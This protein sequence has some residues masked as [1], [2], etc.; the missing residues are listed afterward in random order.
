[1]VKIPADIQIL[2]KKINDVLNLNQY[3]CTV[4]KQEQIGLRIVIMKLVFCICQ[5]KKLVAQS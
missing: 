3:F 5:T 4:Q 2:L 1:M